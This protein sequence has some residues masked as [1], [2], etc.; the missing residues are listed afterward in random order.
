MPTKIEMPLMPPQIVRQKA[1]RKRDEWEKRTIEDER[2]KNAVDAFAQLD[3]KK[4]QQVED[5]THQ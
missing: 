3:I 1:S 5:V 4:K 2:E